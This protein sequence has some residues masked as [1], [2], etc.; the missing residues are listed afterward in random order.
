MQDLWSARSKRS[1]TSC[2][3]IDIS[4]RMGTIFSM[5]G[6]RSAEQPAGPVAAH[7]RSSKQGD[8]AD[9]L[10]QGHVAF[11]IGPAC[12]S[13]WTTR[14]ANAAR[15]DRTGSSTVTA[16]LNSTSRSSLQEGGAGRSSRPAAC[17]TSV[18]SYLKRVVGIYRCVDRSS[19]QAAGS[20]STSARC[21]SCMGTA[22]TGVSRC[23]FRDGQREAR[24]Q[25]C[26]SG[27]GQQ[28][29]WISR[30]PASSAR[31]ISLPRRAR[32][33]TRSTPW[34]RTPTPSIYEVNKACIQPERRACRS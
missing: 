34:I 19:S 6:H 14:I 21:R 33:K 5:P 20:I 29:A 25:P 23:R 28:P 10:H 26:G 9:R 8:D 24:S 17:A 30:A 18:T 7:A 4:T 13:G 15:N 1:R 22:R 31:S 2:R 27:R 16:S 3:E 12:R 11:R 32:L